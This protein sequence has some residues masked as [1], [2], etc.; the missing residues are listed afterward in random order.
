MR[1]GQLALCAC[2]ASGVL[3]PVA[4]NRVT[5]MLNQIKIVSND[6]LDRPAK[7]REIALFPGA[8]FAGFGCGQVLHLVFGRIVNLMSHG[9]E[10]W[11]DLGAPAFA[12]VR[13]IFNGAC[14]IE[15]HEKRL[16]AIQGCRSTQIWRSLGRV[17]QR[18][19]SEERR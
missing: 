10:R 6:L 18:F 5:A 14:E 8:K 19:R 3:V 13:R 15:K 2:A 12:M 16:S 17:F 7:A 4:D 11:S 9:L 1:E